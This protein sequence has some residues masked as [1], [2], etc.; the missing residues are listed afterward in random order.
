MAENPEPKRQKVI[1]D[2]DICGVGIEFNADKHEYKIDG[3]LCTSVTRYI[4]DTLKPD[5]AWNAIKH[6][7]VQTIKKRCTIWKDM[8]PKYRPHEREMA[9][10]SIK[11]TEYTKSLWPLEYDKY[12]S[13]ETWRK[14]EHFMS[15]E[16]TPGENDGTVYP[17]PFGNV[18]FELIE[19]SWSDTSITGSVM[20]AQ[21]ESYLK[22][23]MDP[24]KNEKPEFQETVEYQNFL[25]FYQSNPQYQFIKS[26][27]RVG[28]KELGICGTIDAVAL[29]ENGDLVLIDWKCTNSIISTNP[30]TDKDFPRARMFNK[31][32]QKMK[33]TK[34]NIYKL[35][36]NTYAY[37]LE[38]YNVKV[39]KLIVVQCYHQLS[40]PVVIQLENIR[41]DPVFQN[42]IR[43]N[44]KE[45]KVDGPMDDWIQASRP[46]I[47]E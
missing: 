34:R 37:I 40:E 42:W 32:F 21:I 41:D 1:P 8:Y 30:Q 29:D 44:K 12:Y 16:M 35:Q 39:S 18:T 5:V 14:W 26:E 43:G 24:E 19:T 4:D 23:V 9:M 47:T 45:V 15:T 2:V 38:L 46:V 3:Q 7:L 28:N 22:H 6:N 11:S 25:K 33:A 27:V 31:P 17:P 20:H 10:R 13:Q 36:L